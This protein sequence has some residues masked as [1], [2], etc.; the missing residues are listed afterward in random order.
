M[1]GKIK[2]IIDLIQ[3]SYAIRI[4]QSRLWLFNR[5]IQRIVYSSQYIE[6]SSHRICGIIK[7]INLK[8]SCLNH[9]VRTAAISPFLQG[10]F[11]DDILSGHDN[12][13]SISDPGHFERHFALKRGFRSEMDFS[14]DRCIRDKSRRRSSPC[15]GYANWSIAGKNTTRWRESRERNDASSGVKRDK[16]TY[17]FCYCISG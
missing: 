7:S 3:I 12:Q 14:P 5:I 10:C 15:I 13:A 2:S 16:H 17:N 6:H 9:G 1:T 4:F 8:A 11:Y